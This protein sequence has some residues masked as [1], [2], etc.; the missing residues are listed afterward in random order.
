[1]EPTREDEGDMAGYTWRQIERLA[2]NRRRWQAFSMDLCSTR[3]RR[4]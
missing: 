2:Q 3:S 1:V 4:K